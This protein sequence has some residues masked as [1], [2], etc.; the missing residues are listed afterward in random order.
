MFYE[1]I[2]YIKFI[3][4]IKIEYTTF[5]KFYSFSERFKNQEVK[6]DSFNQ[7]IFM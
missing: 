6:E 3:H 2:K 1:T 5:G 7:T 4:K